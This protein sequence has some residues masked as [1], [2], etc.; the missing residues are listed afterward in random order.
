MFRKLRHH[1]DVAY[2]CTKANDY[3]IAVRVHS[4]LLRLLNGRKVGYFEGVTRGSHLKLERMLTDEES[5]GVAW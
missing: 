4:H 2:F 5:E 3:G 1:E